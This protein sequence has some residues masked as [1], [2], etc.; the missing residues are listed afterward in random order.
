L[1]HFWYFKNVSSSRIL[2]HLKPAAA[3]S[4]S[5]LRVHYQSPSIQLKPSSLL[6][7]C[8]WEKKNPFDNCC[9]QH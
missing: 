7:Y 3:C 2:A 6:Y 1:T 8:C 4:R 9:G 5:M